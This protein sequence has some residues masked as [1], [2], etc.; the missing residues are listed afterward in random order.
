MNRR[1]RLD[2]AVRAARARTGVPGVA[3]AL[4]HGGDVDLAADGVL[5]LGG[6]ERVRV[7]TPFRIASVTKPFTATLAA[8]TL[9]LD[10]AVRARLSHTAG[11]RAESHESLPPALHGLWSYSNA[12]YWA[13][14]EAVAAAADVPFAEAMRMRVL[15][16]LGL[17]ATG[18]GEPARCAR[19]HVQEGETG[20]R[21]VP[22]DAY[23]VERRPSGGLWS[24][25]ADLVRFGR[26][27]LASPSVLHEPVADALGAGY[28]LG[29]WVRT[30]PDGATALD[31]EGSVAGYQSLL[32]LVPER[33]L[34]LA[35]LTNSWRGS[36]LVRRLVETLG[37]APARGGDRAVDPAVAGRYALDDVEARVAVS[38]GA[39]SVAVSEP[40]P[41]TGATLTTRVTARPIGD[42]VFGYGR[43]VL[44]SHRVDFPRPDVARIGWLALPRVSP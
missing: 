21:A 19:G 18:F 3:A 26:H 37:L 13:V 29:F 6:R 27:Q 43:G 39:L 36:G 42:G 32:L 25:V 5:V 11:L 2:E 8:E 1:F 23:A 34:V 22:V 16:P 17:A 24:T 41:V 10:D 12:G 44:Q 38:D 9:E 30:L 31:H 4:A 7:D 15:E 28:A 33:E 35:V 14:G 40:D 20:H